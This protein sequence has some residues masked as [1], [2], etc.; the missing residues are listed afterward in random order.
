[1]WEQTCD[2]KAAPKFM[3]RILLTCLGFSAHCKRIPSRTKTWRLEDAC[4]IE[5]GD[6]AS[7]SINAGRRTSTLLKQSIAL[8]RE[9]RRLTSRNGLV[10]DLLARR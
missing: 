9:V 4:F 6:D 10:E 7:D 5:L 2:S 1:M 3:Y 8:R